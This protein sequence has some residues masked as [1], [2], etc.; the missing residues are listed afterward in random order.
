MCD[1]LERGYFGNELTGIERKT[2]DDF[3]K[4]RLLAGTPYKQIFANQD[5]TRI[6]KRYFFPTSTVNQEAFLNE[7]RMLKE[8]D[9]HPNIISLLNVYISSYEE[10]VC[11]NLVL[12]KLDIDLFDVVRLSNQISFEEQDLYL[13]GIMNG[14][15]HLHSIDIAH[16]DIGLENIVVERNSSGI[17]VSAKIIDLELAIKS[18]EEINYLVEVGKH[19][20]ITPEQVLRKFYDPFKVDV[21][22]FGIIVFA[23][24][25]YNIPFSESCLNDPNYN[26]YKRNLLRNEILKEKYSIDIPVSKKLSSKWNEMFLFIRYIL[27]PEMENRP[28]IEET[29]LF[30]NK[31]VRSLSANKIL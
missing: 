5:G 14:L 25:F 17:P 20:Y 16:R 13:S 4:E 8:I 23:T 18:D 15:K 21:W 1:I 30:Y 26:F 2:S 3:S 11:L 28:T 19:P 10:K 27:E 22:A 24:T 6:T 9:Y 29:I 7:L 12:P 31:H